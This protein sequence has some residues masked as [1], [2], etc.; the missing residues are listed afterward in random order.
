MNSYIEF[1]KPLTVDEQLD[2]IATHKRVVFNAMSREEAAK[3]LEKYGYINVITPFKF[4][5]AKKD[6]HGHIIK[7]SQGNHIYERDIDFK[8][9]Y[10][11]YTEERS[12][13]PGIYKSILQFEDIFGSVLSRECILFYD[14]RDT[15][16]F[17]NFIAELQSNIVLNYSGSQRTHMLN[18]VSD[19][20]EELLKY[21]SIYIFMDRLTLNEKITIFR[22]VD[23]SLKNR[24][25]S[26]LVRLGNT[27]NNTRLTSFDDTLSKL[28]FIRNYVYHGNSLTVLVRYYNIKRKA[29]RRKPDRSAYNKLINRLAE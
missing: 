24:I 23:A 26:I 6:Q 14:I 13:Y 22:N 9:Y 5:F 16:K 29:F 3:V 19:F 7:D 18:S 17:S 10:D 11:K 4:H 21:E 8:E 25:F 28:V 27:F 15:E 2:H 20:E 1:K 12:K